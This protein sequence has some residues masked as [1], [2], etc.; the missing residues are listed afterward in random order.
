L[1]RPESEIDALN[2][3]TALV[4]GAGRN[5]GRAIAMAMAMAGANVVVN[6]R[7]NHDEGDSVADEVRRLGVDAVAIQADVGDPDAVREMARTAIDRFGSVDVLVNNAAVRHREDFLSITPD[8]WDRVIGSNLSGAFYCARAV[9]PSMLDR[10]WG[11]IINISGTDGFQGRALRAH[12]VAA[13]GGLGGL[14]KSIAV[15]F[16]HQ[17]ITCNVVVPGIMDTTRDP[18]H[19]PDWPP[20]QETLD[21]LPVPRMGQ[22]DE[23]GRVCAFLASDDSS[24]IT[25]QTIH[26]SG[27]WYMP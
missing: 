14:T 18:E 9:I 7:S 11:R 24:Y 6:Y 2:G 4:T 20:S 21:S 3:K 27:G 10:E 23:V 26:V 16:G 25:G 17:G 13:K 22:S 5:I 19:Y 1:T 8:E 12:N 15:E